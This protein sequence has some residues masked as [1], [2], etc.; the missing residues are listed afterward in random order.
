MVVEHQRKQASS[1]VAPTCT[2]K[3]LR[4]VV[5]AAEGA[6]R[7]RSV[8]LQCGIAVLCAVTVLLLSTHAADVSTLCFLAS[9]ASIR[10]SS[11]QAATAVTH[12]ERLSSD[13][14]LSGFAHGTQAARLGPRTPLSSAA[15]SAAEN[16]EVGSIAVDQGCV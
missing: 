3:G 6:E 1:L 16:V 5:L 14:S 4:A 9:D 10:L 12:F 15:T 13:Y 11:I 8:R 7:R 2:C